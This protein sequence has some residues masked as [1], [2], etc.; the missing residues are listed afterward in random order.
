MAEGSTAGSFRCAQLR[1]RLEV[2]HNTKLGQNL[3]DSQRL[4]DSLATDLQDWQVQTVEPSSECVISQ[5]TFVSIQADLKHRSCSSRGRLNHAAIVRRI[6]YE[7]VLPRVN[8]L[9]Q[10]NPDDLHIANMF[11]T[12]ERL[13][14]LFRIQF[15][16]IHFWKSSAKSSEWSIERIHTGKHNVL[17]EV[18]RIAAT[19]PRSMPVVADA[20]MVL[21]SLYTKF[22]EGTTFFAQL[23]QSMGTVGLS[24][25]LSDFRDRYWNDKDRLGLLKIDGLQ[26][27]WSKSLNTLV[28]FRSLIDDIELWVEDLSNNRTISAQNLYDTMLKLDLA[29]TALS[30]YRKQMSEV[31]AAILKSHSQDGQLSRRIIGLMTTFLAAGIYAAF[32]ANAGSRAVLDIAATATT[33]FYGKEADAL[34]QIG[35]EEALI[36]DHNSKIHQLMD[37][38]SNAKFA[39]AAF[40]CERFLQLPVASMSKREQRHVMECLGVNSH[41][42][43]RKAPGGELDTRALEIL[44]EKCEDFQKHLAELMRRSGLKEAL[45]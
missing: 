11:P 41:E 37:A 43:V 18:C 6:F 7:V 12:G 38:L 35:A 2:W 31:N 42:L 9:F 26:E 23:N 14:D 28:C 5:E 40:F 34:M 15:T 36:E 32:S 21:N 1:V 30:D 33:P 4:V 27:A 29:A 10:Q 22:T 25:I 17:M 44:C 24:Q 8:E 16:H 13:S 19:I 39:V 20:Y 45:V 3:Q